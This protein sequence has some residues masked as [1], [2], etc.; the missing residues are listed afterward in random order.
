MFIFNIFFIHLCI[1]FSKQKFMFDVISKSWGKND[2]H[3]RSELL[4]NLGEKKYTRKHLNVSYRWLNYWDNNG[5]LLTDNS[6]FGKWRKFSYEEFIWLELLRE[7]REFGI[8]AKQ[9]IPIREQLAQRVTLLEMT[10]MDLQLGLSEEI[11]AQISP[12]QLETLKRVESHPEEFPELEEVSISVFGMFVTSAIIEKK[13]TGV[14]LFKNGDFLPYSDLYLSKEN[15]HPEW[16]N[17]KTLWFKNRYKSHLFISLTDIIIASIKN[18]KINPPSNPLA[19]LS[20]DENEVVNL[21]RKGSLKSLNV[22][23][24][25]SKISLIEA[26]ENKSIDLETRFLDVIMKEGYQ[27]ISFK[28]EKGKIVS[29]E[30]TRKIRPKQEK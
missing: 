10:I 23:F 24:N 9:I 21:I 6:D 13:I 14:V 3:V 27:T 25:G 29:F 30:N 28:T 19:V 17:V 26:T 22:R 1:L 18:E 2:L 20:K 7:L 8:S 11:K 4:L 15:D 12:D 5:L 16:Q